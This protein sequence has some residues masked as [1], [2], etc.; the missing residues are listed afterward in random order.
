MKRFLLIIGILLPMM[1]GATGIRDY[2]S[3]QQI[4]LLISECR[5]YEGTEVVQLGRL[6]T[7]ALKGAIRIAAMS[8]PEAREIL[9]L[10]KGIKGISVFDFSGC[11]EEDKNDI[12]SRLE[13]ILGKAEVLMEAKEGSDRVSLFGVVDDN[14][15]ML[16]DLVMYA[17][18]DCALICLFGSIPA[19]KAV[20]IIDND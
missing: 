6:G 8:D 12:I 10:A 7:G 1:A 5:H 9:K 2:I 17:P 19:E 11:C 20:H 16:N 13:G 14:S 18:N 15:Q 4:K 3:R